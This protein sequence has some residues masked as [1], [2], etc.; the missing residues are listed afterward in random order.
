MNILLFVRR[1]SGTLDI[2]IVIGIGLMTEEPS[3]NCKFDPYCTI[4]LVPISLSIILKANMNSDIP[5]QTAAIFF[6]TN[7]HLKQGIG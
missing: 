3:L 7:F 1:L 6:L 2:I 4:E 5:L